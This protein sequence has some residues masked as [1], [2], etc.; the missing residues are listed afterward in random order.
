MCVTYSTDDPFIPAETAQ[1]FVQ[2]KLN[3]PM[4][5]VTQVDSAGETTYKGK[6]VLS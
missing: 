1:E 3:I 6:D 4:A 5:N 2:E